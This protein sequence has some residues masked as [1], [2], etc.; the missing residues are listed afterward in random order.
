MG[1]SFRIP[2]YDRFI[3]NFTS[4]HFSYF[5]YFA[6]CVYNFSSFKIICQYKF[7]FFR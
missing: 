1:V 6:S 7:Y 2:H 5:H 4:F 3:A